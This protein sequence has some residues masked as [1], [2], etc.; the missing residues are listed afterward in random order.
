[1]EKHGNLAA[2]QR[3]EFDVLVI[4]GGILGCGIARDAAMRGLRTALVEKEDFGYGTTSRSTRLI[5]GGLRYLELYDFALVHEALH[6]RE[7][8]LRVAPHLV[9]GV[10]FVTPVY[11]GDRWS[12]LLVR[13]G[14]VLYD[15]LSWGKSL[16]A[17]RM[18]SPREVLQ[19]EP[20]LRPEGLRGGALYYDGQV[21]FPE[22]LCIE[23]LLSAREYGAC[24]ANHAPARE[25]VREEGRVV[26]AVVEET[27][28]GCRYTLRARV[29]VNAAGPW[30]DEVAHLAA[31]N[32][33][34]HLRRTKGIHI[35]VP[36]FTQHAV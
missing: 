16:P 2:M 15:L 9:H 28:T 31:P 13:S 36:S 6:E 22:R 10:P 1:M 23:N 17:H 26:G 32:T 25:L 33:P 5:H 34:P 3:Q 29:V 8:L 4:G 18:L 11:Q 24:F 21:S 12:P 19:L 35:V 30:A 14:M 27:H 7:T 20:G